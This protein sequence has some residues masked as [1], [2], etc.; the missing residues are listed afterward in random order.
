MLKMHRLEACA[1]NGLPSSIWRRAAVIQ[2]VAQASCLCRPAPRI[3]WEAR[4]F[5]V[6][7]GGPA[8]R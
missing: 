1:T 4:F 3:Q 8:K 6:Q 2:L 7:Q 5:D